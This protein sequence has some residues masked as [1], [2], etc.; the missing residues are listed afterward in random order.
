MSL[1]VQFVTLAMMVISGIGMGA[2]FDGYRVVSNELRI[3]RLWIPLLDLLYWAAATLIVFRVLASSNEGE[4]RVYVFLGLMIGIAFYFWLLSGTVIRLV[5]GYQAAVRSLIRLGIRTFDLFVV[6]PVVLLVR[7]LRII[8]GCAIVF[9]LFLVRI[10]VQLCRPFWLFFR[11]L[12]APVAGPLWRKLRGWSESLG[13]N[14]LYRRMADIICTIR[15]KW[16]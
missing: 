12:S 9:S 1:Q 11:W 3:G 4:V 8:L 13:L 7:L 14:G 15:K 5:R 2:A 10:V 16:F 6:R